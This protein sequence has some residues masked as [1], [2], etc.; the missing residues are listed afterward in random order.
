MGVAPEPSQAQFFSFEI[1]RTFDFRL[2]QDAM[3]QSVLGAGYENQF[4]DS[5]RKGT[6]I[7]SAPVIATSPSP[8]SIAAVTM[9]AE[10]IK[11]S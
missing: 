6:V 11:T 5:L 3:R 8:L 7:D 9:A 2:S 4:R 10:E 1:L